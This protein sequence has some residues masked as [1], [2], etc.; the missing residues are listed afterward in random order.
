MIFYLVLL[1]S[2][3]LQAASCLS[4]L[5]R[6]IP[7]VDI[8]ARE[9]G[10]AKKIMVIGQMHGDE[11]ESGILTEAWLYR[12]QKLSPSNHWRVIPRLNPD[13][14]I[15][16]TRYNAN[17]VDINRNFPTK[18]WDHSHDDPRRNPGPEAGSEVE[19]KCVIA[20]IE[21]FKPDIVVS[22]HTPYG[23]FDFDGPADKHIPNKLLPWKRLGTFRGSLGR[24]LWDERN[25]PVLT[26]EIDPKTFKSTQ[27]GLIQLQDRIT[28]LLVQ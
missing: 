21:E 19:T 6:D 17:K 10:R 23:L 18:D 28:D 14:V 20:H 3:G 22:I 12:L 9:G 15:Q 2:S 8:P 11:V 5:K 27:A 13:G 7:F 24:Y 25:V 26:I 4:T 16:K 1:L